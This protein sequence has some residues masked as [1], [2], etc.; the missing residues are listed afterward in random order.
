[1]LLIKLTKHTMSEYL[2][3]AND[4]KDP[5]IKDQIAMAFKTQDESKLKDALEQ[6]RNPTQVMRA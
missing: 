2:E 3:R 4:I 5:K 1:M 6:L